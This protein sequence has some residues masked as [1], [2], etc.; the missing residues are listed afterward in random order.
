MLICRI[1]IKTTFG[2]LPLV[3]LAVIDLKRIPAYESSF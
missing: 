1:N 3:L 2:M